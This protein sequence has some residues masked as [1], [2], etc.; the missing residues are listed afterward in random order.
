MRSLLYLD[1]DYHYD[2]DDDDNDGEDATNDND[3]G[4][5]GY[6]HYGTYTTIWHIITIRHRL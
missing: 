4:N 2:D 3:G 5:S 1:D 6:V